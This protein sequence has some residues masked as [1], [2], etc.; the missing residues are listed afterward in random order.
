MAPNPVLGI[1]L[2]ALGGLAAASFYVPSRGARGWSWET[3]WLTQAF[4][5]WFLVP[6]VGAWLTVPDLLEILSA[7]PSSA[8]IRSFAFGAAYGIGG[9][10]FGLGLRYLGFSLNY[11]VALGFTAALGTILPPIVAGDAMTLLTTVSGLVVLVGISVCLAGITVCGY[12]GFLKEQNLSIEEKRKAVKEFAFKKGFPIAVFAGSMSACFAFALEA[13]KPIAQVAQEHGT[14]SILRNT[15]IYIFAM[16]GAFCTNAVWCIL[17]GIKNRTLH[18]YI[19]VNPLGL[20]LGRNFFLAMIGGSLWYSQFFCYGMGTTKMGKYDF[21]SWSIH[22][23]FIIIFS[24]LIGIAFKEWKGA[25]GRTHALIATG[26]MVLVLAV[27]IIGYANFIAEQEPEGPSDISA[28]RD[29]SDADDFRF[30]GGL[31][32]RDCGDAVW[33]STTTAGKPAR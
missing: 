15:P 7:S 8:M 32:R 5:S 6:I 9:L 26:L 31:A 10:T 12:A 28:V 24:N 16:G 19:G 13:G 27:C 25:G 17:L 2:H 21:A 29:S 4:F 30:A 23:A 1:A 14:D 20:G 33:F 22:M 18:E 11:A 3:Y